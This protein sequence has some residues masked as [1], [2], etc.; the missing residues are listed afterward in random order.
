[1]KPKPTYEE[2]VETLR[3]LI[4]WQEYMGGWE[5]SVWKKAKAIV[6]KVRKHA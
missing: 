6:K 4:Q 5:A 2:L 3:T 1:M